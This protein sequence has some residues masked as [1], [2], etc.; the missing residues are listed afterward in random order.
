MSGS[1]QGDEDFSITARNTTNGS[2][3]MTWSTGASVEA[4]LQ[5][6]P[7]PS[8]WA[9]L[10]A[11]A[12]IVAPLARR[13]PYLPSWYQSTLRVATITAA[14]TPNSSRLPSTSALFSEMSRPYRAAYSAVSAAQKPAARPQEP[15]TKRR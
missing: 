14:S 4:V 9:M 10:L 15:I 5:A 2:I 1:K 7:E 6:V 11:G 12:A 13:A 8:Q 3:R